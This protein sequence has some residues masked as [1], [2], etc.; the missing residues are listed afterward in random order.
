MTFSPTL[1]TREERKQAQY[2]CV[3]PV[4]MN[5]QKPLERIPLAQ[6]QASFRRLLDPANYF[7]LAKSLAGLGEVK[8]FQ[9]GVLRSGA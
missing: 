3:E 4:G 7:L 9:Q 5:V 8:A 2:R 6:V 1:L